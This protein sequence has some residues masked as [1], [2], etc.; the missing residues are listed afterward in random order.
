MAFTDPIL[1]LSHLELQKGMSVI[2]IGAGSGRY[3]IASANLVGDN[4][5]VYAVD[6]Q[7]DLLGKLKREASKLRL[8]NIY[9]IWADI[10][11]KESTK[12][13]D[14][15]VDAVILSN[16]LFQVEN[17]KNV[18]DEAVRI[19]K[20]GGKVLLIDWS[21]S[22]G[23]IGPQEKDVLSKSMAESL[24]LSCGLSLLLE[25]EAGDH[26]YGFLFIKR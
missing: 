15:T 14:Q 17:K 5:K 21:D 24:L 16:I 26:H 6:I 13:K 19:L 4:G 7:Q 9:P 1:N 11:G 18:V 20:K 12:L 23:G 10:E 25:F 2:D 8:Q 3:A 22:F